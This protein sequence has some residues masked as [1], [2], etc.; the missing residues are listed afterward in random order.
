MVHLRVY[1]GER[2]YSCNVCVKSFTQ[3]PA[4]KQHKQTHKTAEIKECKFNKTFHEKD[5][6][7]VHTR[8]HTGEKPY[9]CG[10]CDKSFSQTS[11]LIQ[12]NKRHSGEKP[13]KCHVQREHT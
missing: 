11:D 6:L 3:L 5:K 4:L 2:P 13:F 10:T 9:S 8:I 12:H 1:T 7:K